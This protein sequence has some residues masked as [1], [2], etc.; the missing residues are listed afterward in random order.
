MESLGRWVSVVTEVD[1]ERLLEARVLANARK[2]TKQW[3]SVFFFQ[4]CYQK[5]A[6]INLETCSETVFARILEDVYCELRN[7]KGEL[8]KGAS[9]LYLHASLQRLI[10]ELSRPFNICSGQ[11]FKSSQP[12]A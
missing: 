1:K 10:T 12:A 3:L 11:A 9:Y 4:F 5:G 7:S 6:S 8:C 2:A